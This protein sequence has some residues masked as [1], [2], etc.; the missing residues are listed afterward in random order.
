MAAASQVDSE[1]TFRILVTTDN[2]VGYQDKDKIRSDDAIN[3]LDEILQLARSQGADFVL[4]GGDLFH[5]NKPSR[6]SLYKTMELLRKHC[7]GPGEVNFE[8]VSEPRNHFDHGH[9]NYEDPNFNVEIPFFMIHGNH[10]DPGGEGNLS[11]ANLLEVANLIN[12]F[13]RATSLEEIILRPILMRKGNTKVALYGLGNIRDERL[14]R[15]FRDKKVHFEAPV[16]V[17]DWFHILIL[18]QNRHKGNAAGVPNKACIHEQMLP[19]FL[20]LVIWGH[21]H[22]CLIEPA[23]SLRGEFYIIQPGS[24]VATSLN[25]GEEGMKHVGLVEVNGANFRCVP[26]PLWSVRSFVMHDLVLSEMGLARTN[27]EGIWNTLTRAAEELVKKG[28]EEQSRRAA[29]LKSS[30]SEVNLPELPLVRLRVE[31]TGFE[32]ISSQ[33]FGHQFVGRVANPEEILLFHK[34]KGGTGSRSGGAE[35]GDNL[36]IEDAMQEADD[37]SRIQDIVYRYL[38][39]GHNLQ[40][41]PEP[42]LNVAV[43]QFVHKGEPI[44]IEAFVKATVEATNRK[45]TQEGSAANEDGI[46]KDITDRADVIR[47][48]RLAATSGEGE[49]SAAPAPLAPPGTADDFHATKV[50][51][52][53][54]PKD[55]LGED[56]FGQL[57]SAPTGLGLK[58]SGSK[59]FGAKESQSGGRGRAGGGRGARGGRGRGGQVQ[60]ALSF[61]EG[62][63]RPRPDDDVVCVDPPVAAGNIKTPRLSTAPRP[64]VMTSAAESELAATPGATPA[65]TPFMRRIR[66]GP[67]DSTGFGDLTG[68]GDVAPTPQTAPSQPPTVKRQWKFKG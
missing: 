41:L 57:P 59:V 19:S 24:S 6:T 25:A 60:T 67:P 30:N 13:G 44:A 36:V 48:M 1:N 17:D 62:V 39:G 34:R 27:E 28:N 33:R 10:D 66:G 4:N 11:A 23:E 58:A 49:P 64:S 8:V 2:H 7:L 32:V 20:D 26:L 45:V 35:M 43:Q 16:D 53:V 38:E 3:T 9:V 29:G 54:A 14:N 61:T 63:K 18:H 12:Y 15:A 5:D 55:D 56:L 68:L 37:G 40:I 22:D 47:K 52:K 21:E 65:A 51:V 46:R 42:D 31:H 50:A